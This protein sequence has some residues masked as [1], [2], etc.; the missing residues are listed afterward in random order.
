MLFFL[1]N[2]RASE[3]IVT[4]MGTLFRQLFAGMVF[5]SPLILNALSYRSNAG[6]GVYFLFVLS[7]LSLKQCQ[8]VREHFSTE[9]ILQ[10]LLIMV[11]FMR[12]TCVVGRARVPIKALRG[13]VIII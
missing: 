4:T 7:L 12:K 11:L 9:Q 6:L 13:Y 8:V 2:E 3:N 5:F 10:S 1:L